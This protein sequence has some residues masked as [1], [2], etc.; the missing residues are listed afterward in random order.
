MCVC[1]CV[2]V[3]VSVGGVQMCDAYDIIKLHNN[4]KVAMET[5]SHDQAHHCTVC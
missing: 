5:R 2:C 3:C 1:V 4:E